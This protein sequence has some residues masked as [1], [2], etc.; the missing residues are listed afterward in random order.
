MIKRSFS[1]DQV[2]DQPLPNHKSA[3]AK[4]LGLSLNLLL[5]LMLNLFIAELLLNYLAKLKP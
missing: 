2:I 4:S 1:Y 3:I 5:T